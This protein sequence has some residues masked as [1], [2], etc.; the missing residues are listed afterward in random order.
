MHVEIPH[1]ILSSVWML[2]TY[3]KLCWFLQNT[4]LVQG[5]RIIRDWMWFKD[6][7]RWSQ[8]TSL[9][10]ARK[11]TWAVHSKEVCSCNSVEMKY[12]G[13][14]RISLPVLPGFSYSTT[15]LLR[16]E[17]RKRAIGEE[18]SRYRLHLQPACCHAL[19][20]FKT[21]LKK[22]LTSDDSTSS[23]SAALHNSHS[24]WCG[25]QFKKITVKWFCTCKYKDLMLL[26]QKCLLPLAHHS[27]K[28]NKRH[29]ALQKQTLEIRI[30]H[31]QF[32]WNSWNKSYVGKMVN[33]LV[34]CLWKS[35]GRGLCL[36]KREFSSG[37]SLL[38]KKSSWK[39]I[40]LA[41]DYLTYSHVSNLVT[42]CWNKIRLG[43]IRYLFNRQNSR[44]LC[45]HRPSTICCR[46]FK[47]CLDHLK[48][49][50]A[51]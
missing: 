16:L 11:R 34:K 1:S 44:I 5:C 28:H 30:C 21:V 40:G 36:S 32:I 7:N 9:S 14:R 10:S 43:V 12:R 18:E 50:C 19:S 25:Q 22:K 6:V 29:F 20:V 26:F 13:E 35:T 2:R 33:D 48:C 45:E 42:Q 15:E 37:A 8:H 41:K 4:W 24:A 23:V 38:P 47:G 49:T 39:L 31:R 51:W 27:V 3:T 17:K 46:P